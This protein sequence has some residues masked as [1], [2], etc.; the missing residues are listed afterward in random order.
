MLVFLA[1]NSPPASHAEPT[2][3]R[4]ALERFFTADELESEWFA[5]SFLDAVPFAQLQPI[6]EQVTG[7]LGEF[8]SL[9]KDGDRW[10]AYFRD[11]Y[12]P[13]YA[14]LDDQGRFVGLRLL[15]PIGRAATLEEAAETLDTQPG[16]TALLVRRGTE[17]V[18]ARDADRPL[19]VGSTFKLVVLE[20]LRRTVESGDRRWEDTVTLREEWKSLPSGVLQS[21]PDGSPLTLQTLATLMISRSDN[22]ATDHLMRVLGRD[23]VEAADPSGRN[24]PFLT[25]GEA[26]RL[27]DPA[28]EDLLAVWREA[29]E[30]GRREVLEQLTDRP[31]PS[32]AIFDGG[33]LAPDVEWVFTTEELCELIGQLADLDLMG[34]NPGVVSSGDWARV[35]YKGGSEPGVL[36]LTTWVED[37]EGTGLCVSATRNA[38]SEVEFSAV[39]SAVA[40]MFDLLRKE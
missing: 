8:E 2:D 35:A 18:L 29:D 10:L 14:S 19:A 36:N 33:P 23:A 9:E 21:W 40:R 16:S 5:P 20:A 6:R 17:T 3:V 13:T 12:V 28:N 26:F 30:G 15:P 27:K 37:E 32:A 22:T 39:S 34:I 11:A 7:S 31:L 38:D 25:T 4:A 24:R 1:L